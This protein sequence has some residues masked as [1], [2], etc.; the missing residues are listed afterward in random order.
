M[1]RILLITAALLIGC[2]VLLRTGIESSSLRGNSLSLEGQ[3]LAASNQ[4]ANV[5]SDVD[6]RRQ[7]LERETAESDSV[8]K[9]LAEVARRRS[10]ASVDAVV[11]STP[12]PNKLPTWNP[13]SPYVWLE[14]PLLKRMPFPVFG[15][16]GSLSPPASEFLAL[17]PGEANRLNES[18]KRLVTE[19]QRQEASRSRV[20]QEHLPNIAN[21]PG[22]KFTV[23]IEPGTEVSVDLRTKAEAALTEHLGVQRM[24]LFN[25]PI[26]DGLSKL[27]GKQ[28]LG[29]R[30]LS[31]VSIPNGMFMVAEQ[32]GDSETSRECCFS[33]IRGKVPEHLHHLIPTEFIPQSKEP[34]EP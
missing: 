32:Q 25:R 12:F 6:S 10:Q 20:V 8:V 29:V 26:T 28:P 18:L 9:E 1:K 7:D 19:H 16:N 21:D 14:K 27:F 17:Q 24:E 31:F 4:L 13:E 33:D 34:E 23:R 15:L 2:L 11:T 5:H 30:T 3:V 22:P